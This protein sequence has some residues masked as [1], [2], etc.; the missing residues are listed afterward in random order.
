MRIN[1]R[2][3]RARV[4]GDE[5]KEEDEDEGEREIELLREEDARKEQ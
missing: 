5:E 2:A 1:F 4:A 3:C